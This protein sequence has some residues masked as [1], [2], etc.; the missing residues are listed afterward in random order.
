M[1]KYSVESDLDSVKY[2]FKKKLN[3]LLNS[4]DIAAKE[5]IEKRDIVLCNLSLKIQDEYFM[6]CQN[7]AKQ[8]L[9]EGC[10]F[11]FDLDQHNDKLRQ[12][13]CDMVKLSNLQ[14]EDMGKGQ[15]CLDPMLASSLKRHCSLFLY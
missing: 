10:K 3:P 14:M 6:M 4:S 1:K 5:K 2:S 12:C 11:F 15:V 7:N 13:F 8:V 9:T